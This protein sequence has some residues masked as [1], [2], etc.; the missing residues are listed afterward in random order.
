MLTRTGS[1]RWSKVAASKSG[2]HKAGVFAL[3][4]E[5]LKI[6]SAGSGRIPRWLSCQRAPKGCA[7][8][9]YSSSDNPQQPSAR[10]IIFWWRS[11]HNHRQ[12]QLQVFE[13]GDFF[14]AELRPEK[15]S[16]YATISG[17]RY[18]AESIAF[19]G[20]AVA[21]AELQGRRDRW[22]RPTAPRRRRLLASDHLQH[23]TEG[24]GG[25]RNHYQAR[26]VVFQ[27]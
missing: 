10:G 19:S 12:S 22:C 18:P 26:P 17:C 5:D 2:Q 14:Q 9:A 3:R 8:P 7:D 11:R 15:E 23:S 16:R 25:K 1:Q 4:P 6:T 21:G 13:R 27:G 24:V 20:F